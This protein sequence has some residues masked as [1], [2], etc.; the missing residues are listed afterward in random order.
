MVILFT[1]RSPEPKRSFCLNYL[2]T[3]KKIVYSP[4]AFHVIPQCNISMNTFLTNVPILYPLRTQ[5]NLW[6]SSVF[7]GYS[8]GTLARSMLT[9]GQTVVFEC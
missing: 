2:P 5:K 1:Q 8:M 4:P 3:P 7:K 9:S 6:F